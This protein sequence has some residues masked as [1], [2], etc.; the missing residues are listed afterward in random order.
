MGVV[1]EGSD[2]IVFYNIKTQAFSM[3][4]TAHKKFPLKDSKNHNGVVV[5]WTKNIE[6]TEFRL[7]EYTDKS[8]F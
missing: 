1:L 7:M 4:D 3:V 6:G 8:T 2:F 5:K